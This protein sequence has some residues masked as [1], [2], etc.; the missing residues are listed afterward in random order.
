[1]REKVLKEDLYDLDKTIDK[2]ILPLLEDF[3][4]II[5]KNGIDKF[6]IDGEKLWCEIIES[7]IIAF[8][9]NLSG[10]YSGERL[11]LYEKGMNLFARYFHT[12][13]Y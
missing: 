7:M 6:K 2:L 8:E 13:W 12:L 10:D 11:N 1:M 5:K 9:I 3:Y 4:K